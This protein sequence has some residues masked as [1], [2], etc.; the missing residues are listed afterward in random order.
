M[1]GQSA[2]EALTVNGKIERV[3]GGGRCYA[4]AIEGGVLQWF[5]KE[6]NG[7]SAIVPLTVALQNIWQ[8]YEPNKKKK[9]SAY[10]AIQETGMIHADS[11]DYAK[12][13]NGTLRWFHKGT[14]AL[15]KEPVSFE[16]IECLSWTPYRE[17][18]EI[19][20]EKAGELWQHEVRGLAFIYES[21]EN[22]HFIIS[23]DG[24]TEEL[25]KCNLVA[26]NKNG[27]TRIYPPV[28]DDSVERIE[29]EGVKWKD[30][31]TIRGQFCYPQSSDKNF[32]NLRNKPP[33][34]MILEIPKEKS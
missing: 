6:T 19:R 16:D 15:C 13:L 5:F 4:K 1:K 12:I 7:P 9:P 14:G 2:L 22:T 33:M 29:I 30:A 20:P 25:N 10:G 11:L 28:E 8:P 17:A 31:E 32:G 23:V 27:W 21:T 26:H 3:T 18:R 34:K 24:Q